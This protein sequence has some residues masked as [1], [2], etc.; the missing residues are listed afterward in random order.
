MSVDPRMREVGNF[1]ADAPLD[2]Q[3]AQLESNAVNAF[4]AVKRQASPLLKPTSTQV[5]DYNAKLDELVVTGA[6]MKVRLPAPAA[7]NAGR[8]VGVLLTTGTVTSSTVDGQVQ[9]ASSDALTVPGFYE[10][11]SVGTGWWRHA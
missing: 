6:T 7:A 2:R 8:R 9:G 1:D 10:Y 11:V 4:E 5:A 3:L